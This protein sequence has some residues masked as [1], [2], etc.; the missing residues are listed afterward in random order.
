MKKMIVPLLAG[1]IAVLALSGCFSPKQVVQTKKTFSFDHTP[2]ENTT[3]GS[4]NMLLAFIKPYYATEFTSGNGELFRSFQK[5][6]GNDVE[7][8]IIAK[9]FNLKG[10][11]E[12]FD[13]MVFEEKKQ[14]SITIQIE[15]APRFTA[16]EGNWK[17]NAALLG[18]GGIT[19]TYSGKVS[20]IGKINING[21]EPL[22]NQKIWAK[23]VSIPNIEN[24]PIQTSN[25][26]TRTLSDAELINDP[27]VYNELGKALMQQ[28]EGI[29]KKI[30]SHFSVEE[31]NSLKG[32]IKELKLKKGY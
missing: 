31:F 29:M 20:L 5:A 24:I 9:G 17:A 16:A 32:Q 25:K 14:T 12:S 30:E 10:P 6:L 26:Y 4:A 1:G 3:S 8:L 19:Y 23:S 21:I 28:Y 27:G 18:Y 7:E 13:E 22:T 11:Y 15:I 2:T